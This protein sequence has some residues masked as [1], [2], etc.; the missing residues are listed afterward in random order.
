[1]IGTRSDRMPTEGTFLMV[2]TLSAVRPAFCMAEKAM[3]LSDGLMRPQAWAWR[4]AMASPMTMRA[5]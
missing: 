5:S 4:G 3:V 2:R 1:M